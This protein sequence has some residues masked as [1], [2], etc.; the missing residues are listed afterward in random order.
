MPKAPGTPSEDAAW[1]LR[2][3]V[4]SLPE[5]ALARK[6][7]LA[8]GEG[9][10]LRVKLG[11]D[12]TAPDIHLGHT[13][14]LSKL[15]EFQ[16]L[17]HQVVLIIGDY[18]ARVGDPSGRSQMR[19]VL[20]GEQID[21]NAATF[22]EQAGRV[23]DLDAVELRRNGEWLDMPA[24]QLFGLARS[25]TVA[26]MLERD[27]FARRYSAREPI[28]LLELLYPLL[29]GFD[30]VAVKSDV[31]LGGTDQTFNLL[32]ARDV[33]RDHG[34]AQQAVLTMPLLRGL[35]GSEKMSKSLGNDIGVRVP[36]AEMYAR[37]LSI[38]DTLL[39]EWCALLGGEELQAYAAVGPGPRDLKRSLAR[40]LVDRFHGAGAGETAE[41]AFDRVFVD[42]G[43]PEQVEEAQIERSAAEVHLP[44]LIAGLFGISRGEAR[45]LITQGAVRIDGDQ[46]QAGELDIPATLLDGR[47]LAVGKRQHRRLRIAPE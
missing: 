45:R 1:L 14:V 28:S 16:R 42:G 5:G 23:L 29:Q 35:D 8:A 25:A 46:L 15:A 43:L 11:I 6:L 44:A 2:N 32:L 37:T 39:D 34:M 13:V 24:E 12:P 18:T 33:Q 47:V 4:S 31:E 21:A 27:D 38:P 9:R 3:A 40:D 10:P 17:G 20:S 30:S 7:E 41:Q 36:P 19:P 26:Q 22:A